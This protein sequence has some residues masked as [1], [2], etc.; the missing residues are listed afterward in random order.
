MRENS[1][2]EQPVEVQSFQLIA[3]LQVEAQPHRHLEGQL[4]LIDLGTVLRCSNIN[5]DEPGCDRVFTFSRN[6]DAQVCRLAPWRANSAGLDAD[7]I[8]PA[9]FRT[10]SLS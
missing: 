2:T 5:T 9:V 1:A 4:R 7:F 3:G 10:D 8:E 6:A